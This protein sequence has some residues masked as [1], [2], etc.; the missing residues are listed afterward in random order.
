M[1]VCIP[2]ESASL[3]APV[4]PRL[5][6]AGC[7]VIIDTHSQEIVGVIPNEQDLQAAS[8]AGVQAAELIADSGAEAVVCANVGP[9]AFR[10]LRSAGI[11]V[12]VGAAGTAA[13]AVGAFRNGQLLPADGPNVA[14]GGPE[15]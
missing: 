7:F 9:R 12:Y 1:R 11:Q 13:E 14:G 6:R 8:G 15:Q 4:D 3:E 10:A 5:G 2:T